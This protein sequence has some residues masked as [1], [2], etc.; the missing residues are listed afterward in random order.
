MRALRGA[1][2]ACGSGQMV[3]GIL[4]GNVLTVG[5]AA[6]CIVYGGAMLSELGRPPAP[7]WWLNS[8]LNGI[9]LLFAKT[10][11]SF[12]GLPARNLAGTRQ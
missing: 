8:H 3:I 2:A 5:F 1:M 4:K 11:A 12:V 9:S 7:D 10:H 6:I